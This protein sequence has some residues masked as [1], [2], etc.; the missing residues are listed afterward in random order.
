MDIAHLIADIRKKANLSQIELANILGASLVAVNKWEN[1]TGSPS[2][3]QLQHLEELHQALQRRRWTRPD[4]KAKNG[5]FA[6]RGLSRAS[7]ANTLFDYLVPE[8]VLNQTPN[9]PILSRL[10]SGAYFSEKGPQILNELLS[11]YQ[12]PA[13]VAPAPPPSGMSAGKNTYTYDA[14]TYHTKVP[15][16]GIA[17][18]IAHYLPEGGLVFDPFAGSGMTA[19][20]CNATGHDCVLNELSPAACF[21]ANRFTSALDPTLFEAGVRA[22]LD[23]LNDLRKRL[24]TTRCR[25]CHNPT[26]ILYTIWSYHVICSHCGHEFLLWDQA[27]SYG[28]SVKEHKIVAKFPCP[29]C[30]SILNKSY[31]ER[32]AASPVRIVYKCCQKE[33]K[34]HPLNEEDMARIEEIEAN[35][36]LAPGFYP[37]T[38][39]PD[40]VNL[41]QPKK[42]GLDS[43]D[44]LYTTR[45]LAAMS[46]LWKTI[47]L[48][49]DEEVAAFLAFVFTSLYQRVTRLSEFRFWGG[50]GNMARFNVPFVF[51]EANVFDTFARKARTIQDHLQTTA[52]KYQARTLVV[53]NSATDLYYLPDNSVDLIFTDPPFGANIN[54]SEMNILWEAWLGDFTDTTNEAIINKFQAKGIT[55]YQELM[56][57]SLTECYRV[58]RPGHWMLLVFMNSSQEVWAA[59]KEAITK[60]GFVIHRIDIFDKQHATFKQ[61]VSDNTAGADLVLH[62][63]KSQADLNESPVFAV[64]TRQD[65]QDFLKTIDPKSYISE[66]IHVDREAEFDYRRLYS[67]WLSKA[68]ISDV[69]PIDFSEFRALVKLWLNQYHRD[70][71]S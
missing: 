55:Q 67:E 19:V 15:P 58:L 26:E 61:L 12:T 57:K 56:A 52:S 46:Q 45:N 60:A 13:P 70:L 3:A 8:V 66:F 22:V 41:R 36:P 6:S 9:P 39:L 20:A 69:S 47:H 40:G 53:R 2:P 42:H 49:N 33:Y 63:Y 4:P 71:L 28:K 14:H 30:Q 44:K 29:C 68:L 34:R 24:Y 50:S 18:L 43:I 54:Y 21:I 37:T 48:V 5:T 38:S 7:Y 17:E 1:G 25:E 27:Q 32:A 51:K 59:L 11:T 64:M 10:M 23:A 65:L 62:C 31:L 35:P 16:Q